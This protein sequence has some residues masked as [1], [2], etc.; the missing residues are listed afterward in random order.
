MA[1]PI[2]TVMMKISSHIT[3]IFLSLLILLSSSNCYAKNAFSADEEIQNYEQGIKVKTIEDQEI[4]EMSDSSQELESHLNEIA[5]DL[6]TTINK[7]N[8]IEKELQ[9]M[10][11]TEE[12]L[13]KFASAHNVDVAEKE[14]YQ[15]RYY[16]LDIY[17]H[18]R[19]MLKNEPSNFYNKYLN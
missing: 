5:R 10:Q 6:G 19:L 4:A 14:Y 9:Y 16:D 15:G 18:A 7:I 2:Y 13:N 12:E 3:K 17:D 1:L 11:T 8:S